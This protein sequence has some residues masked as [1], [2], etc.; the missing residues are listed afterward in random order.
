GKPVLLIA[1]GLFMYFS[2]NELKPLFSAIADRFAGGEMLFEMLAPFLVGKSKR[3]DSVKSMDGAAEFKWSMKDCRNLAAWHPGI[4]VVREW[5]YFDHY[6]D[7]W[8]LFGTIARLPILRP[9]FASRLVHAQ[10][11]ETTALAAA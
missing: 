11:K 9:Q 3:H 4:E 6:K 8:K 5:N 1:E 2:E 10:L 7:R